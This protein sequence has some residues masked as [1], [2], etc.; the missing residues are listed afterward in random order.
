MKKLRCEGIFTHREYDVVTDQPP[1]YIIYKRSSGGV[2]E[3]SEHFNGLTAI[4][5]GKRKNYGERKAQVMSDFLHKVYRGGTATPPGKKTTTKERHIAQLMKNTNPLYVRSDSLEHIYRGCSFPYSYSPEGGFLQVEKHCLSTPTRGSQVKQSNRLNRL[6][7]VKQSN[8]L[9]R[10]SQVKQSNRLNRLS[11]VKQSNRPNRLS[12]K[13]RPTVKTGRKI[14]HQTRT[15]HF[16]DHM[17][18]LFHERLRMKDK[19]VAVLLSFLYHHRVV[20]NLRV[21]SMIEMHIEN[22]VPLG[23]SPRHGEK[24]NKGRG[25]TKEVFTL[26]FDMHA[27]NDKCVDY[28]S[29]FLNKFHCEDVNGD[30]FFT[31]SF[32]TNL[33]YVHSRRLKEEICYNN[34]TLVE[35]LNRGVLLLSYLFTQ[36]GRTDRLVSRGTSIAKA[37][38][39]YTI[40]VEDRVVYIPTLF[41]DHLYFPSD[42]IMYWEDSNQ[43]E[44]QRTVVNLTVEKQ[45]KGE[46]MKRDCRV[47]VRVACDEAAC[48]EAACDGAACDGAACG[49]SPLRDCTAI[50][51]D[52][53]PNGVVLDKERLASPHLTASFADI[54]SYKCVAPHSVTK[55]RVSLSQGR[56]SFG[57]FTLGGL[58]QG[59]VSPE[60]E[61]EGEYLSEASIGDLPGVVPLPTAGEDAAG[62]GT[63]GGSSHQ[64]CAAFSFDIQISSRYVAPCERGEQLKRSTAK[65]GVHLSGGETPPTYGD[66]TCTDY[67]AVV[68]S[69]AKVFLNCGGD[70]KESPTTHHNERNATL[71][72]DARRVY[73]KG[74]EDML[75]VHTR[76]FFFFLSEVSFVQ[77][78]SP[79]WE[80]DR[81]GS[82]AE[83]SN[84]QRSSVEGSDVQ[85]GGDGRKGEG[86]PAT[87]AANPLAAYSLARTIN[88]ESVMNKRIIYNEILSGVPPW[89]HVAVANDLEMLRWPPPSG[90]APEGGAD[91]YVDVVYVHSVPRG[92]DSY[93]HVMCVS[94]LTSALLV[95]CTF[96]L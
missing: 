5:K 38:R 67:D 72:A 15:T 87:L 30:T 49:V 21:K 25:F 85:R 69:N 52:L 26:S 36:M 7:Q 6:S 91:Y 92:S 42:Y 56:P 71:Y 54:E 4:I 44:R 81:Q 33:M 3:A 89:Q 29:F 39:S 12:T 62:E 47:M 19:G 28:L 27:R 76:D 40:G 78:L 68:L 51:M 11:Q 64:P 53:H 95:L 74:G 48:D 70:G 57:G 88:Y 90:H 45:F 59:T 58:A 10:L 80:G 55:Y 2:Y 37:R 60:R 16:E 65:K 23:E 41:R 94:V 93:L 79:R 82:S 86:P 61:G 83:G 24:L 18:E 84:A 35:G 63:A 66:N 14:T 9:N 96:V 50:V 73:I 77:V 1:Y 32:L 75:S 31:N 8:R 43:L 17:R 22:G 34:D 13:G 46:G 20:R